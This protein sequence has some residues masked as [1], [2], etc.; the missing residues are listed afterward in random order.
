MRGQGHPLYVK[1]EQNDVNILIL[2]YKFSVSNCVIYL[3][4]LEVCFANMLDCS[5]GLTS[6][7]QGHTVRVKVNISSAELST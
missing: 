2:F 3:L 7:C 1:V 6:Q 5:D 4:L